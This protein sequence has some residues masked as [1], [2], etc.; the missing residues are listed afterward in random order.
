MA[1]SVS[2]VY[3]KT[4][5]KLINITI[6]WL[7]FLFKTQRPKGFFQFEILINFLVSY[8]RFIR[9]PMLWVYGYSKYFYSYIAVIDFRR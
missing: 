8:F 7:N 3:N 5:Q 9:I 2:S 6:K 4:E 1:V